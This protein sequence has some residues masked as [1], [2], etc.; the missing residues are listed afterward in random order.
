MS[1]QC[2]QIER[3]CVATKQ[4]HVATELAKAKRNY[5]ATERLYVAIE[6]AKVGRISIATKDFYVATELATI[7]SSAAHNKARREKDGAHDSV[8]PCHVATWHSRVVTKLA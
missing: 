2:G 4:F 1:R 3:F 7:E 8:A 5:V 6:L